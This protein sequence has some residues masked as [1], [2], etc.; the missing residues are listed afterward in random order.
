MCIRDRY[1]SELTEDG[2]YYVYSSLDPNVIGVCSGEN[3]E[4]LE[5]SLIDWIDPYVYQEYITNIQKLSISTDTVQ[6]EFRLEH[7]VDDENRALLSV[8]TEGRALPEDYIPEFR[9]FYKSL[10]ALAIQ[11][12]YAADEYAT[13]TLEE[14]EAFAADPENAY[15]CLLYTSRCV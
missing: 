14:M 7:D 9:D 5:Y 10:V 15:I 4:Y 11:D 2:T 8:T 6:A 12:Y 1:F 13:M 3:H